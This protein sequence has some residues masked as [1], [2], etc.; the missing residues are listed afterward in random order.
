MATMK[1]SNNAL[2]YYN[3]SNSKNNLT[4]VVGLYFLSNKIIIVIILKNK[5]A[6]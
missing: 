5:I 6:V 4:A 3:V 2:I 1:I